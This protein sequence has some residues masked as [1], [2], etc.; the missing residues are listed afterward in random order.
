M[1]ANGGYYALAVIAGVGIGVAVT[2]ILQYIKKKK[3]EETVVEE[4]TTEN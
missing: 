4:T 3:K 2:L 1:L